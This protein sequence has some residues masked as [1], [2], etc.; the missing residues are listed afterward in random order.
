MGDQIDFLIRISPDLLFG[1]PGNRPGGLLL[2][3]LL[4]ATAL[5]VGTIIAIIVG[6]GSHSRFW[7]LRSLSSAWVHVIRGVPLVVQLVL[8]HQT[9]GAGR[10]PGVDTS[11]IWSAF[12]TLVLY[13]SAYQADIVRSGISAVPKSQID[14]AQLLGASRWAIKRT[15]IL[16][17]SLKIMRPALLTQAI[18]VFKD[19]S[20]VVVLG[21]ADLTTNAR[22][23]LGGDVGNT[24]YWVATYLLVGAMYFVVAW[25]SAVFLKRSGY[26]PLNNFETSSQHRTVVVLDS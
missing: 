3:V 10:I 7:I 17:G 1:F 26:M 12:V 11:A 4:T 6:F 20:V 18:T 14:D 19:S 23:A 9:L 5:L 21:V 2:S 8:I 24:P 15:I 22:I 25:G 16:P 13:S